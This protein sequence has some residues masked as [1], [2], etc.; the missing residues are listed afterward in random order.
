MSQGKKTAI[1]LV[2]R[3]GL[4]RMVD[5]A[6]REYESGF[7]VFGQQTAEELIGGDI[8]FHKKRAEPSFF[9]GQILSFRVQP[10]GKYADRIIFRFRPLQSHKGIAA[11]TEG[12]GQEKKIVR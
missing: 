9:G 5:R 11:G 2:E 3:V 6:S 7:W 4:M 1:H 8:Y 10:D 12:W